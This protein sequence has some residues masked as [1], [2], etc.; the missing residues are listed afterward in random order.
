MLHYYHIIHGN[1]LEMQLRHSKID[2]ERGVTVFYEKIIISLV[3]GQVEGVINP[4]PVPCG[5]PP[6]NF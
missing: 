3:T 2:F 4:T 5:T 6:V 1:R